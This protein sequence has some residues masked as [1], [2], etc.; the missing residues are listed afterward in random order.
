MKDK[1]SYIGDL[2]E[3]TSFEMEE[4]NAGESGWYWA[5]FYAG[6]AWAAITKTGGA[7]ISASTSMI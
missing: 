5:S 2:V 7:S 3:L 6:C 4:I 1:N